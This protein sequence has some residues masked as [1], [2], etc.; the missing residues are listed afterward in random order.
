MRVGCY[1]SARVQCNALQDIQRYSNSDI[2][3]KL[4]M[5][6]KTETQY[7]CDFSYPNP[8]YIYLYYLIGGDRRLPFHNQIWASP[9]HSSGVIL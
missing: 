4:N 6:L 8:P 3:F 5:W 1:Y 9:C 7:R 2:P